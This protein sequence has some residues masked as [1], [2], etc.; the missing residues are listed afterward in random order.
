MTDRV[1]DQQ[2]LRDDLA[3]LR[4]EGREAVA[5]RPGRT[6]R[7][8]PALAALAVVALA[9][10]LWRFAQPLTVPTA[11]AERQR[12][13]AAGPLPVLS[14]SG[15]VVTGDRYLAV[16]VRVP[17][18][19]DRYFVEEGQSVRRGDPLVRLDSR[20]YAAAVQA[21][22][23]RLEVARANVRLAEAELARGR[24]LRQSGVIS[25]QELDVL[26]NKA[27][28]ARATVAQ[29]EADLAQ[30]RVNLEYTELRAP[31]DGVVLAK[32]KEVGEIAVPGGF[33]GSG[34]LV[35]LANLEE[36]RAEVDVNEADLSRVRLGQR[37]SVTPDALPDRVY[38]AEVVKLYPQVD[39]QKGTL[40]VE[41]RILDPDERLLPDMSARITFYAEPEAGD[42]A[43]VVLVPAAA[44]RRDERGEALVWVVDGTRVRATRVETAGHVGERVRV[45]SGLSGGETVVVGEQPL[46]EGQRVRPAA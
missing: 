43:P 44:V 13:A 35:R 14:G 27:A 17:G 19:I 6:R 38:R 46:R 12:A 30:A 25:Q 40:K 45:T 31:V 23:A 4:I 33:A 11:T 37:A 18:R 15:Y 10:L 7:W 9:V 39:R 5:P 26:Q 22:A 2:Q 29:S 24:A 34:D 1:R 28:V 42:T 20:D 41:V 32:L 21:A 3:S 16:G 8:W 36:M